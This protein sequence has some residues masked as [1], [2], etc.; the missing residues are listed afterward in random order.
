MVEH[1]CSGLAGADAQCQQLASAVGH[2]EHTWRAYLSAP[3][4]DGQPAIHAR[5]RIGRG[6]W[7]NV[8]GQ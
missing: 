1:G 8:A 5:D 3:P 6:P 4:A 7:V 2:G